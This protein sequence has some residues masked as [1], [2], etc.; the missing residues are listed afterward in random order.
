MNTAMPFAEVLD[1]AHQL[2]CD[3]QKELIDRLNLALAQAGHRRILNDIQES[4]REFALGLISP[5]TPE[6]IMRG[7]LK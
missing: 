7:A 2:S 6:E 3:E 1:A 4:E 5:S